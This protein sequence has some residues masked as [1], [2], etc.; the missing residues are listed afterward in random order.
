MDENPLN[1]KVC[2]YITVDFW[3]DIVVT[4]FT[5]PSGA[6]GRD[7]LWDNG[8]PDGVNGLAGS[9]YAGYSNIVIDDFTAPEQWTVTDG[10]FRFCWNS[11]YGAGNLADVNVY[12][13]QDLGGCTPDLVELAIPTVTSFTDVAT[14][15]Y[16]FSRPEI[17]VDVEF[18]AVTLAPGTY[19]VGF[20][21]VG[22]IDNIAYMLTA[23][24][25]GCSIYADLPYWGYP[26]WTDG[27][28]L[29][30]AYYDL[31]W[32]LTGSAGGGGT[33]PTPDIYIPCGET[34]II[35]EVC[36]EGVFDEYGVI[37]DL[38][39]TEYVSDPLGVV[40]FTATQTID[41]MAGECQ[42]VDFGTYD[43]NMNGVFQ[44]DVTA[45]APG[46]DCYPDNNA[47]TL[48]VGTDCCP[49]EADHTLDPLYP[50]GENNWYLQDVEVTITAEDL[51]CPDP[52]EGTASGIDYIVYILNGEEFEVNGDTTTFMVTEEG[53]NLIEYWAVDNVGNVGDPFTFEVAIDKSKPSVDFIFEKIED[54]T[55][56]VE[57]TAY[58]T[59]TVSGI[60]KVEFYIDSSLE[61]TVT[62]PPYKW[63]I[64]WDAAYKTKTFKAI[65]YDLAGNSAYETI[66]G[67]D[68]P[69]PRVHS[70]QSTNLP[71]SVP[72]TVTQ[73]I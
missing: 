44:L 1:D 4:G 6:K 17:A 46:V 66:A 62:T 51:P 14:G 16:Y 24:V 20:Q 2:E 22:V 49:P 26:R 33:I 72:R 23:P 27:Y 15:N 57:F 52:C 35:G 34:S 25:Q 31:A 48:V 59:D 60:A 45:T 47:V 63:L 28:V 13:Y 18:D 69:G 40:D 8:M 7:L 21:P 53:V 3:H 64:T 58:A 10:H 42:E 61:L 39:L 56:Q 55:L 70:S 68:I 54:G 19:W 41:L 30:G 36:N 29:W 5:S 43:F 32:Q 12:F 37:V 9:M 71:S 50:D 73:G 65:A 67:S 11:A 38:V